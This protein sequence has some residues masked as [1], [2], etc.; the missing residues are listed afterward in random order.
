MLCEGY[1]NVKCHRFI[2]LVRIFSKRLLLDALLCQQPIFYLS[3][4]PSFNTSDNSPVQKYV[5]K[6][7]VR[8]HVWNSLVH[9]HHYKRCHSAHQHGVESTECRLPILGV[10]PS[11]TLLTL[12]VRV[13]TA[14]LL[15]DRGDQ[16]DPVTILIVS[17]LYVHR[18]ITKIYPLIVHR[19]QCADLCV[20]EGCVLP[21]K[22]PHCQHQS[23]YVTQHL[24]FQR[25]GP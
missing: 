1:L 2:F 14:M 5:W 21:L 24:N 15:T 22:S 3:R 18:A 7:R 4:A 11:T 20:C 9:K 19:R 17:S 23:L 12:P 16:P 13:S 8:P 25:R 6:W 10:Q